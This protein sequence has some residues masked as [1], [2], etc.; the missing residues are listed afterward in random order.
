VPILGLRF[1][2]WRGIVLQSYAAN[3]VIPIFLGIIILTYLIFAI[4]ILKLLYF[5]A[6]SYGNVNT[7]V[8]EGIG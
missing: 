5:Q 6:P 7:Y 4:G 3:L 1:A 8:S 2:N